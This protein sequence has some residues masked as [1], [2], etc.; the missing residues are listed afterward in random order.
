MLASGPKAS[1]YD[2]WSLEFFLSVTARLLEDKLNTQSSIN[3]RNSGLMRQFA[4]AVA[5]AAGASV[6]A[7]PG[8]TD[9]AYAQKRDKKKN[10]EEGK[11]QYSK[12]FV[13]AYQPLDAAIK[14][15]GAD[16]AALRPQLTA[17]AQIAASP[18]ERVA[19]G[20]M[21]YNAG[22]TINDYQ[23]ALQG[24]EMMLGSGKV[25]AEANGQYNF[26]AYT[27]ANALNDYPKARSFLQKA[28]DYNY[29]TEKVSTADLE[30]TMAESYFS[31]NE[32]AA[33]FDY[34]GKAMA[35][36]KAQGLP[37]DEQW[38][39]RGVSVAYS[40]KVVP[41]LYDLVADWLTDY[42]TE[43]NWRD[44]I[45]LAR[46]LNDYE[47]PEILDLLRL[48]KWAGVL[49]EKQDYLYY[50]EAADPRRL[51]KEV[52]DLIDSAYAS[53]SV[54][55]DDIFVADS[56][57]TANSR[58]K[59]DQAELPALERDASAA[60]AGMRTV[61]AAGD[62]F[63]SYGEYSKAAGFYQKSLGMPGVD[64]NTA[65]TRLG[66]A[67]VGMGDYTAAQETFAQVEGMRMP[68]AKLWG[69][70]AAQKGGSGTT[71]GG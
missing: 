65:L 50:I 34:L 16:I 44:G 17:L 19:T 7:A 10:K 14:A 53:G 70:F 25:P 52:K 18:D 4:L 22:T 42:P 32:F 37:V 55:K 60:S 8:L 26:A 13:E 67:Q 58:I 23:M 21:L 43:P 5:L 47:G 61:F 41:Q 9:P 45:N 59:T 27:L 64:R 15:E 69:V 36:R 35:A 30:I 49:T 56:L 63:L 3:R 31:A 2:T 33:G 54:S 57:A 62:A 46:N 38:Y 66:I 51:P 20:S 39:R 28:I 71:A 6:V 11:A 40:N 48:S 12:E 24:M 1:A 68:I 29:S